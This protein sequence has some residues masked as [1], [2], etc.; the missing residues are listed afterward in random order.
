MATIEPSRPGGTV[1]AVTAAGDDRTFVLGEQG[2]DRKAVTFYRFRLN[3]SGQPGAL[4]RLP[5]SVADGKTMTGVALSPD[6]TQIAIAIA[7]GGGIQQVRLYPVGGASIRT[8]SATGGTIGDPFDIRS[9][10]WATS[11]RTLAVN[12]WARPDAERPAARPR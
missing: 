7:P 8:W 1:V 10:S 9:L 11:Q 2:R 12:W 4:T 6:G 3:A 5:M